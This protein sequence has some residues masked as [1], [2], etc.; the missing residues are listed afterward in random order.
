[1]FSTKQMTEG[2]RNVIRWAASLSS[3]L[4]VTSQFIKEVLR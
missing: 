1:M 3:G 4:A 2:V